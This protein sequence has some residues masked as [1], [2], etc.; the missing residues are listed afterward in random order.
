MLQKNC[1]ERYQSAEGLLYD[2]SYCRDNF[3]KSSQFSIAQKDY[4]AQFN[5][6]QKIYGR[7]REL[8]I[9]CNKFVQVLNGETVFLLLTGYSGIG[10]SAI[11]YEFQKEI[12]IQGAYFAS[13]KY[14][15]K[16]K[17]LFL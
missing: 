4:S 14:E 17:E 11:V 16:K 5:I 12:V 6:K 13:G 2:L 9:L 10:K 1:D 3:S 7:E 15:E 8:T